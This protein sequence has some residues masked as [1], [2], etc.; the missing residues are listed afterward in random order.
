MESPQEL[1]DALDGLAPRSVGS[2]PSFEEMQQ[3]VGRRR[4]RNRIA[5][6]GAVMAMAVVVAVGVL[7]IGD[8]PS[9][10]VTAADDVPVAEATDDDSADTD[11]EVS[12][13][14]PAEEPTETEDEAT[15]DPDPGPDVE[16]AEPTSTVVV[17]NNGSLQAGEAMTVET[18]ASEVAF[19]GGSGVHVAAVD[20]EWRAIAS[21]FGGSSGVRMIGLRSDDGLAWE[22]A[23][24]SGLPA[25]ATISVV[26]ETQAGAFVALVS[27]FD[28]DAQTMFHFVAT[29]ADLFSWAVTPSLPAGTDVP[30]DVTVSDDSVVVIGDGSSPMV[31]GGPL[32]GPYE[33]L[34]RIETAR[35]VVGVVPASDGFVAA[36]SGLSGASLF[37]ST[38][39]REWQENELSM[40]DDDLET[41]R[42]MSLTTNGDTLVLA[43]GPG[44]IGGMSWSATSTDGGETWARLDLGDAAVEAV[45]SSGGEVGFLGTASGAS[46]VMLAD[47]QTS[48]QVALD[49][50]PGAR[51]ELLAARPGEAILLAD[52]SG[53][54]VWIRASR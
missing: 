21:S 7:S 23:S 50:E 46:T 39:G 44:D 54:L 38:D 8:E 35:G 22:D 18:R 48:D 26:R 9:D 20:G 37:V 15:G 36:G 43:G 3:T 29:S 12:P 42:V 31:W 33:A 34:G 19:G 45:A 1:R 52:T 11:V 6:S 16:S 51:V 40:L 32:G 10:V 41:G 53:G 25:G 49:L 28:V 13:E 2:A 24:V 27:S 5:T 14:A 30:I 4:A 17:E 47:G